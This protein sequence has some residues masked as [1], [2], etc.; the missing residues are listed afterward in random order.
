MEHDSAKSRRL[1]K[2]ERKSYDLSTVGTD[3]DAIFLEKLIAEE[4][5]PE[6]KEALERSIVGCPKRPAANVID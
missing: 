2:L 4:K 6:L 1:E 3:S 5:N